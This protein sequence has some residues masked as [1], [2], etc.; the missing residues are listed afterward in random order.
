MNDHVLHSRKLAAL[1]EI[2]EAD[3][4]LIRA[5]TALRRAG[6]ELTASSI[7]RV[8]VDV[9]RELAMARGACGVDAQHR[10]VG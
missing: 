9:R 3:R 4:C 10:R 5:A 7:D 6:M 1:A 8:G 2:E